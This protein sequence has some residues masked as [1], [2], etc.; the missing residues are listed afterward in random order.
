MRILLW[1]TGNGNWKHIPPL[2][3]TLERDIFPVPI[4]RLILF[5]FIIGRSEIGI[6]AGARGPRSPEGGGALENYIL[7]PSILGSKELY[8]PYFDPGIY[9]HYGHAC[10]CLWHRGGDNEANTML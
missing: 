6:R 2:W 3:L 10:S 7:P 8:S 1:A 9:S 5:R 4:A